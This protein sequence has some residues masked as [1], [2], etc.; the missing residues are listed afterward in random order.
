MITIVFIQ[1]IRNIFRMTKDDNQKHTKTNECKRLQ[2]GILI[3][4]K[5]LYASREFEKY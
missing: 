2:V 3:T 1:A 4:L 5:Q